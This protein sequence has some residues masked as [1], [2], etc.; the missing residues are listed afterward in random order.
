[1]DKRRR[2]LELVK[3]ALIVLLSASAL[4][5]ILQTDHYGRLVENSRLLTALSSM[6][7]GGETGA[8][9]GT[10]TATGEFASGVVTPA[11]ISVSSVA[12]M[13]Y[14]LKYDGEGLKSS[15]SHFSALLGEALGS[16][17]A[18][19]ERTEQQWREALSAE[20]V[21]FDFL[22]ALPLR[23]LSGLLGTE[24]SSAAG[25]DAARRLCLAREGEGVALWYIRE[26]DGRIFRCGT[27]LS[28]GSLSVRLEPYAP[29]GAYFAWETGVEDSLEP[30]FLFLESLPALYALS[31]EYGQPGAPVMEAILDALDMNRYVAARYDEA[32]GTIVYVEGDSSLRLHADGT[33]V[34]G[35]IGGETP[36]DGETAGVFSAERASAAAETALRLAGTVL[37][38]YGG[39]YPLFCAGQR[40][41]PGTDEY[42]VQFDYMADGIPVRP[43]GESAVTVTVR[44]D[45]VVRMSALLC[46]FQRGERVS[47]L[48]ELQAAAVVTASGGGEPMLVYELYGGVAAPGW[49]IR[50]AA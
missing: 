40:Y 13:R 31:W 8:H 22:G 46:A 6:L 32:D 25:T 17:G 20:G 30:D 16:S 37:D 2:Y 27:A 21:W 23:T 28:Y 33:L 9:T 36:G 18:P 12:G 14:G 26:R 39:E 15:F 43:G 4:L 44:G 38:S 34:F 1:M 47:P 41:T 45:T 42:T 5:L 49:A 11:A 48:P 19:E 24:M 10:G 50:P 35:L 3:S 7:G 29:N